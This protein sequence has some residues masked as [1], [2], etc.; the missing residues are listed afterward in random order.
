MKVGILGLG[1]VGMSFAYILPKHGHEVY[2]FDNNPDRMKKL[3]DG[4]YA[5]GC[6]EEVGAES[7]FFLGCTDMFSGYA[8]TRAAKVMEHGTV[9]SA[10]FSAKT[11]EQQAFME[12]GRDDIT[13]WSIHTLFAPPGMG[14]PADGSFKGKRIAEIP[15]SGCWRGDGSEHPAITEFRETLKVEGASFKKIYTIEDHDRRMGRIQGAT[16]AENM[17]TARTL[18]GLGINSLRDG[19]IY[20]DGHGRVNFQMAL[21]AIG[22]E[23]SSNPVVYGGIVIMNPYALMDIT[24]YS[25]TLEWLIR[26]VREDPKEAA[27]ML[28]HA[29][30]ALGRG[31][32]EEALALWKTKFE[33]DFGPPG[34]GRNSKSSHLAETLLWSQPGYPM[35]MFA[36]ISAPPY[37]MREM[38]ALIALSE[39]D[40]CLA[41]M[42]RG[43]THD[44]DFLDVLKEYAE[45]ATRAAAEKNRQAITE[46]E[47]R[48]FAPVRL[49]FPDDIKGIGVKT[50]DLIGRI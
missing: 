28:R 29:G 43:D 15:V 3:P 11:P 5:C 42:R 6:E 44:E 27:A 20:S 50:N 38:L 18:A 13:Y 16:S 17:C 1:P 39:H 32:I 41:N 36:D 8:L 46:L 21:R 47:K 48:F 2:A 4:V 26:I 33:S 9:F 45:W 22:E 23:G 31:R 35:D 10:D 24:E 40:C 49:A 19:S 7:E 30:G 25:D 34:G 12:A 14:K 37:R